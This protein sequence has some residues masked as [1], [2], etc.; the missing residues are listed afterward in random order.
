MKKNC[1]ARSAAQTGLVLANRL[2]AETATKFLPGPLGVA[3]LALLG[4]L[5]VGSGPTNRHGL[6]VAWSAQV[7][8]AANQEPCPVTRRARGSRGQ[9]SRLGLDRAPSGAT[10]A[11]PLVTRPADEP[12][13]KPEERKSRIPLLGRSKGAKED[14][15]EESDRDAKG[16]V[17]TPRQ[18]PF[19]ASSRASQG[20]LPAAG[21][22]RTTP[23]PAAAGRSATPARPTSRARSAPPAAESTPP[24]SRR[25]G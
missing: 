25:C 22:R 9:P 15:K 10:S 17:E 3:R 1:H 23:E 14:K 24:I 11:R 21:A 8:I 7:P 2:G 6:W 16:K 19:A 12:A 4:R 20:T 13:P 5:A 18:A